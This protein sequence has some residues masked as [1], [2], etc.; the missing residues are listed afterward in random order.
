M[1]ITTAKI[2][3][4]GRPGEAGN[5]STSTAAG[6]HGTFSGRAEEAARVRREIAAYLETCPA[7]ADAILIA[8]EIAANAIIHTRSRGST[9]HVRCQLSP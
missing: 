7:A 9:F 1:P 2:D 8:R 6:Y 5:P 3:P 4:P